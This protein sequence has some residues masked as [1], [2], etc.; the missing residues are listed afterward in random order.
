MV[1]AKVIVT[2]KLGVHARPAVKLVE[3]VRSFDAA[4][5]FVNGEQ[6]APGDS[7]MAILLLESSFGKELTVRCHGAQGAQ[8]LAAI[9]QLFATGFGESN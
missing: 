1:E 4:V 7:V 6:S 2:N 5:E 3:L 8:A 9:Q